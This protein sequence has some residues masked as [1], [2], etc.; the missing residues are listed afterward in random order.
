MKEIPI[1]FSTE[2]VKAIL[3][4]K[5][6]QTRRIIKEFD[7]KDWRFSY[8][9]GDGYFCFKNHSYEHGVNVLNPMVIKCRYGQ[10]NDVLWVREKWMPLIHRDRS[11]D[12]GYAA[13]LTDNIDKLKWKPSIHMPKD[14]ARIWLRRTGLGLS[15]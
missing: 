1:L 8:D 14:A 10:T 12:F 6:T 5:K 2:M 9:R 11:S 7:P 13:D 15:G 3:D 4:G